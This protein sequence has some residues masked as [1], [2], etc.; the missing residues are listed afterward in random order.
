MLGVEQEVEAHI[1]LIK[2]QEST[3][4]KATSNINQDEAPNMTEDEV[5]RD[6]QKK[7]SRGQS[8]KRMKSQL[9]IQVQKNS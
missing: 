6:P 4:Q 1:H 9:E 2:E 5:L 3:L 7:V 8:R